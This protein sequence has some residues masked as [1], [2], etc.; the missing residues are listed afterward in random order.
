MTVIHDP[1]NTQKLDK[2]YAYI[3]VDENGNEGIMAIPTQ[4]GTT[5]LITGSP[6]LFYTFGK[7]VDRV[8]D[9]TDKKIIS[10][11]FERKK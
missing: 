10:A 7:M 9:M 3:S 4:L 6:E 8:R 5:P 11:E 1:E 2:L